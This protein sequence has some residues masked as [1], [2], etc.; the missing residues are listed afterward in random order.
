M[1][2]RVQTCKAVSRVRDRRG[3]RCRTALLQRA[4][5]TRA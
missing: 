3:E 2:L 4:E 5:E 1:Q